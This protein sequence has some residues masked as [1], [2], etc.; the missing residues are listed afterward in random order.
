MGVKNTQAYMPQYKLSHQKI[1]S[2]K[3]VINANIIAVI[4]L[5]KTLVLLN[6]LLKIFF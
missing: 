3:N 1:T 2:K 4:H 6:F 5:Q